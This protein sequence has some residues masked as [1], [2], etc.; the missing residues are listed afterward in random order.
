MDVTEPANPPPKPVGM[1][2]YLLAALAFV[3]GL[4]VFLGLPSIGWGLLA[5]DRG[6]IRIAL[7]AAAGV[8]LN[9]L[10]YAVLFSRLSHAD[11]PFQELKT[12]LAHDHLRQATLELE[13]W[14]TQHG[15]Y[16]ESLAQLIARPEDVRLAP[17][18]DHTVALTDD[19]APFFYYRLTD[20][21]GHYWLRALGPDEKPFTA[22]DI[23]PELSDSERAKTGLLVVQ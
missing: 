3:P 19:G 2:A 8:A 16:P 14:R 10:G 11:G 23:I 21:R 20:D 4:G 22:D 5:R 15:Q 17:L 9:I 13:Y 7:I 12:R 6:G 18:Y 1:G